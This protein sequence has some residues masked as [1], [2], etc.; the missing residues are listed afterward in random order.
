MSARVNGYDAV[1]ERRLG[2][3][4][5]VFAKGKAFVGKNVLK[6][7]AET[8]NRER[9][10]HAKIDLENGYRLD[11]KRNGKFKMYVDGK[12]IPDRIFDAA[13]AEVSGLNMGNGFRMSAELGKNAADQMKIQSART[14]VGGVI[15]TVT[16]IPRNAEQS[17]AFVGQILGEILQQLTRTQTI[18][19]G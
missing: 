12:E 15:G 4:E 18:T 2:E 6:N 11:C 14:A 5:I 1:P 17:V 3:D 16:S 13:L 9:S 8:M 7:A 10:T 19:R